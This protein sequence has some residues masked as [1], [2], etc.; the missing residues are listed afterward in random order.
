MEVGRLPWK[1]DDAARPIRG[2]F[3]RVECRA[4][5]DVEDPEMTV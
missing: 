1:D 5:A 2:Q 3:C 4:E